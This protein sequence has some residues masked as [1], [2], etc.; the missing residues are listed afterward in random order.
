MPEMTESTISNWNLDDLIH[1]ALIIALIKR[2]VFSDSVYGL[3]TTMKRWLKRA[4]VD[5]YMK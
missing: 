2:K 5:G 4:F 1:C 3:L